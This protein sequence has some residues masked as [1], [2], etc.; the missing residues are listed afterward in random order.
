MAI[1]IITDSAA[2]LSEEL[3]ARHGIEVVPLSLSWPDGVLPEN[4]SNEAFYARL[5][6]C[7]QLPKTAQPSPAAFQDAFERAIADG[8]EV[9]AVLISS[10][11]SG[12]V[13][14]ATIAREAMADKQRVHIF[15]SRNATFGQTLLIL[16]ALRMIDKGMELSDILAVL[17]SERDRISFYAVVTDLKY[18]KM[19]GRISASVATV[20][21]LLHICPIVGVVNGKVESIAKE[22]GRQNAFKRIIEMAKKDGMDTTKPMMFGYTDT[23]DD[24]KLLRQMFAEQGL[25]HNDAGVCSIGY[26]I[27]T[28]GGPGAAGVVFFR[29]MV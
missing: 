21:A 15:D 3:I 6:T 27:G 7:K 1:K 10:G 17:E 9:L 25:L 18:L 29:E 23:D 4:D 16:E 26:T 20:G 19:G 5:K 14:S 24:M 13:Q 12:T 22:R 8:S 2:D 11:I 28:H